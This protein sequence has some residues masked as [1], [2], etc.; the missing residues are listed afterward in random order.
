M[1]TQY[2]FGAGFGVAVALIAALADRRRAGRQDLDQVG[3]VPWPL[4]LVVSMMVA[5]ICA[6]FALRGW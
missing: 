1:Q 6:A 2:W 4:V 5:A 3:W